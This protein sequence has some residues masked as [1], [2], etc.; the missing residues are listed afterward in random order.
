M[1][2]VKNLKESIAA[3]IFMSPCTE[4]QLFEREFVRSESVD[5]LRMLIVQLE[6]DGAIFYRGSKMRVKKSWAKENLG[7][8]EVDV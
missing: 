1:S 2:E 7:S 8:Y 4:S 5:Y 6:T 3:S